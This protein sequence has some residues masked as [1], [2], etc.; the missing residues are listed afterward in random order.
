MGGR[1]KKRRK[2]RPRF[3]RRLPRLFM[4]P[5]CNKQA[6]SVSMRPTE[7]SDYAE[8]TAQCGEC[9]LCVVL[10]VPRLFHPVDVAG[11]VVDVFEDNKELIGDAIKK[12][13]CFSVGTELH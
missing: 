2:A 11:R 5:N 12:G 1:R 3:V 6:L 4:C 8:A 10:T 9:G 13:E 7:G